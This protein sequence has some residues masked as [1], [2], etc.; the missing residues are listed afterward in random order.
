MK[1]RP[2][3]G[4]GK[5][6]AAV[7]PLDPDLEPITGSNAVEWVDAINNCEKRKARIPNCEGDNTIDG[8]LI[9]WRQ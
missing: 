1:H 2:V 6:S 7:F 5:L 8:L 4:V 3:R 9:F